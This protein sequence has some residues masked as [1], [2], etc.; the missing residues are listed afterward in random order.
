MPS[1][2]SAEN[3]AWNRAIKAVEKELDRYHNTLKIYIDAKELV[4]EY[5]ISKT[6]LPDMQKRYQELIAQG[7]GDKQ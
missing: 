6:L 1:T 5:E 4:R 2:T 7:V 3:K